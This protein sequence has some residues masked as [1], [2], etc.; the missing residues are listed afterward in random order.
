MET[1]TLNDTLCLEVQL[2]DR[3]GIAYVA[4][5]FN[6]CTTGA[7]PGTGMI[8]LVG[9]GQG[10]KEATVQLTTQISNQSLPGEYR[11]E[12]LQVQDVLG[13][14]LLHYPD[15]RFRI[16]DVPGDHEGPELLNW[17]FKTESE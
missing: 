2:R 14:H 17:R 15:I 11:C 8:L 7:H 12:Y 5:L 9:D 16:R 10:Q 1:Y 4:A 6:R 13:N 3:S